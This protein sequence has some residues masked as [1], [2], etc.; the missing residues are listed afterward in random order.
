MQ[1]ITWHIVN[2]Q[3]TPQ[4]VNNSN[5]Q[6]QS[7]RCG[8]LLLWSESHACLRNNKHSQLWSCHSQ[9]RPFSGSPLPSKAHTSWWTHLHTHHCH[10]VPTNPPRLPYHYSHFCE[11]IHQLSHAQFIAGFVASKYSLL[12]PLSL[13]ILCLLHHPISVPPLLWTMS[14]DP[15]TEYDKR[16]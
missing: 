10:L 11:H 3:G 15:L 14:N 16:K 12:L 5:V 13:S 7:L 6:D 4:K 8:A 1:L 9:H 2:I